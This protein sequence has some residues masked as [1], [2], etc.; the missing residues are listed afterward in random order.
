MGVQMHLY[1]SHNY[2]IGART[3]KMAAQR[4]AQNGRTEVC[5]LWAHKCL[6]TS[7]AA[8]KNGRAAAQNRGTNAPTQ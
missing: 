1:Q 8:S 6:P 4:P 7:G 5:P 2:K 3:G